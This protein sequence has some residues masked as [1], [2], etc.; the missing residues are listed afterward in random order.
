MGLILKFLMAIRMRKLPATC[1]QDVNGILSSS[2]MF[3]YQT[4]QQTMRFMCA[5][6]FYLHLEVCSRVLRHTSIIVVPP[7]LM[8]KNGG[9]AGLGGTL[10]AM[11][12]M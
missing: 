8:L 4:P 7:V 3:E 6:I 2:S 1:A 5:W 11:K 10:A 12:S 9:T